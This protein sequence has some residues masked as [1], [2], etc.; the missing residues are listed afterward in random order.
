MIRLCILTPLNF[1][2]QFNSEVIS[3]GR[4][5]LHKLFCVALNVVNHATI[6]FNTILFEYDSK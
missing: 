6:W 2:S 5:S 1:T 3:P 4:N